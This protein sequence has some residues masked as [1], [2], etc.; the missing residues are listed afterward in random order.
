MLFNMLEPIYNMGVG[1]VSEL[2][3]PSLFYVCS[4]AIFRETRF[5]HIISGSV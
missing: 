3:T 5:Y 1:D 4:L 2:V